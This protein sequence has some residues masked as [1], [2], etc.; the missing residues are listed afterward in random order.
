MIL[1]N[2]EKRK[3]EWDKK[4]VHGPVIFVRKEEWDQAKEKKERGVDFLLLLGYGWDTHATRMI[5]EACVACWIS[6]LVAGFI[7][8]SLN[9]GLGIS[10]F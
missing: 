2:F 8:F 5:Q 10:F 3:E 7:S 1:C 6:L 9:T 4:S